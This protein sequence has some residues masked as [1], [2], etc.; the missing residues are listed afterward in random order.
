ML[1]ENLEH[2]C[3]KKCYEECGP[4]WYKVHRVLRCGH[5][6]DLECHIIPEDYKCTTVVPIKLDCGHETI[7]LCHIQKVRCPFP[8]DSRLECGHACIRQCHVNNDPDHLEVRTK[9]S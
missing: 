9:S 1:C 7:K 4:C 3:F 5:E 6:H 8:C 2:V